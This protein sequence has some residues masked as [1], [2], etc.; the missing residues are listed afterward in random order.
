[1]AESRRHVVMEIA[2]DS[3]NQ[4]KSRCY[5]SP[6]TRLL[7]RKC[8]AEFFA[9]YFVVFAGCGAIAVNKVYG[10]VTYPGICLTWGLVVMAMV[11]STGHISGAHFNPAITLTLAICKVFPWV[12]V[13]PYFVAQLLGSVLASGTLRLILI[14]STKDYF[15]GSAPAG[16]AFQALVT[17]FIVSFL[18]MFV[19]CGASDEQ[20]VGDLKGLAIGGTITLNVF[21][22]GLVSGSSMNPARS[23]GPAV[24]FNDYRSLWVYF[25][26]PFFGI[27]AGAL[28]RTHVRKLKLLVEEL[29]KTVTKGWGK[30]AAV[31]EVE[32]SSRAQRGSVK[33]AVNLYGENILKGKSQRSKAQVDF[34]K[35][36]ELHMARRDIDRFVSSRNSAERVK[37]EAESELFNARNTV[38]DL[39]LKIEQSNAITKTQKKEI[40]GLKK[41]ERWG[42]EWALDS[43][44]I[45]SPKYHQV[46]RELELVKQELSQL[47]LDMASVLESKQQSE[48]L[49]SSSVSKMKSYSETIEALKKEIEETNEEEVL[50]EL[51]RME[52]VRELSS[53]EAQRQAEAAQFSESIEKACAE[54]DNLIQDIHHSTVLEMNLDIVNSDIHVLENELKLVK[55]MS[56]H[57]GLTSGDSLN[58]IHS[59]EEENEEGKEEESA[60][61]A[62]LETILMEMKEA[63]K[64]LNSIKQESFQFMTSMDVIRGELKRVVAES[65]KQREVEEKT[66][67]KVQNLNSKLLRAKSRLESAT[68][69]EEKA[70]SVL[71][72]L[73]AS[74]QQLETEKEGAK[75][76]TEL[77]REENSSI[78][79]EIQKTESE[80]ELEEER[81]RAAMEELEAVK[82]SEARALESLKVF[83]ERTV[84]ARTSSSLT[85]STITISNFEYEY[86]TRRAE[87]AE[88]IANK[89]VAAAQAWIEALKASEKEVALK[90][91]IVQEE[92]RELREV[93]EQ[94]LYNTENALKAKKAVQSELNN[95]RQVEKRREETKLQPEVAL[96][97]ASKNDIGSPMTMRRSRTRRPT[98]PGLRHVGR[99][100]SV[101]LRKRRRVMPNLAKFFTG[102]KAG[103][104]I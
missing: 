17:E 2:R 47:K 59:L 52:A 14:S 19:I 43:G 4:T 95:W 65:A 44:E 62:A 45:D 13:L 64:E 9:T 54:L 31:A 18:L 51:A 40:R 83:T 12:E 7:L 24:V 90:T 70:R 77:L 8:M 28:G 86:L 32:A 6:K 33:T 21:V 22:A 42:G 101:A 37:A 56:Q 76:E 91:K 61:A 60:S 71:S 85:N 27:F 25:V 97:K 102:N 3:P 68:S 35:A 75:K 41:I 46:M 55:V 100:P 94:E 5:L 50:V 15:F 92:I 53:I 103:R 38:K 26:G 81:L 10:N 49:I 74:L 23:F 29:R 69:A 20:S 63:K 96:R 79:Q 89:K 72:N 11:Y 36:K 34:P 57:N 82:K 87:G 93:E 16:S 58:Q 48:K 30:M 80:I 98:S 104:Q 67:S 78:N 39:S 1:M 84:Q 99:S 88:E 73:T 66:D